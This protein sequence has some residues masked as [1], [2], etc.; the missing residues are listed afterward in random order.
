[1]VK[2]AVRRQAVGFLR[3]AFGASERRACRVITMG[4]SSCRYTTRRAPPTELLKALREEAIK[5]PRFGYRRLHVMLR[6]RGHA[7]NHKCVYRLYRAENLA[8]R[9]KKRKHV[10]AAIRTVPAPPQRPNQ[11]WSIDFVSDALGFGR[12][13]RALTIVDDFTRECLAIEVDTSLPGLRVARVL[14]RIAEQRGAP[15]VVISDNGP[16]FTGAEL[17]KWATGRGVHQHFIRPGK[18]MENGYIESFNGKFRDEC[19][20]GNWFISLA[21]ARARIEAW[22]NDFNSNR[23]HSS[24]GNQTPS[25]F[26][27]SFTELTLRV[28][29]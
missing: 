24:L 23:P 3:A 5:R 20:S 13:F 25:E 6:R 11:R 9:R 17:D 12:R 4:R 22:R 28:V 1:M 16:E 14:E 7:V 10:A 8:I 21:D 19:L 27:K 18:P 15:D 29:Q 26:A 2:P